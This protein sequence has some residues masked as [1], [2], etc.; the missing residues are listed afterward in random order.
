MKDKYESAG[1]NAILTLNFV[2]INY[3]NSYDYADTQFDV[4]NVIITRSATI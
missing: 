4:R 2:R 1:V 3:L